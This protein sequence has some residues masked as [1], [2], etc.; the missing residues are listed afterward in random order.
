[1]MVDIPEDAMPSDVQGL[2]PLVAPPVCLYFPHSDWE[3][4][5]G[6]YMQDIREAGPGGEVWNVEVLCNAPQGTVVTISWTEL[7]QVAE[8]LELTLH[9]CDDE[10]ATVDM[11]DVSS[12][13]FVSTGEG[14]VRSFQ[15]QLSGSAASVEEELVPL[16]TAY[17]LHPSYPNPFSPSVTIRYDLPVASQVTLQVYDVTGRLVRVLADGAAMPAGQHQISWDSEDSAGRSVPS[18]VY[19]Y[20]LEADSYTETR[21][22]MLSR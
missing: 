9:D 17:R 18:G 21:Q 14:S 6:P 1:M 19:F 11:R 7:V 22:M 10:D 5:N 16:P 13:E 15:V 2:E 3:T 8:G 12:Y 20:R 4:D